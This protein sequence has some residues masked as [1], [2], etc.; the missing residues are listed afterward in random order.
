MTV[1]EL[2]QKLHLEWV[3]GRSGADQPVSGAYIGDMLSWVMAK[4]GQGSAWITIQTN[5]EYPRRCCHGRYFLH[6]RS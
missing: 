1:K 4:A 2:Q 3:S 5:T 6:H